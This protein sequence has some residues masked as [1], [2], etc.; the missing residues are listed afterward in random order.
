ME[1]ERDN[2]IDISSYDPFDDPDV[3][4]DCRV[5]G[6]HLE[7]GRLKISYEGEYLWCENLLEDLKKLS[8]F[9]GTEAE[10]TFRNVKSKK[11]EKYSLKNGKLEV[12]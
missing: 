6:E 7:N 5:R 10:I 12:S 1:F 2:P 9:K 3:I 4:P 8:K 11:T